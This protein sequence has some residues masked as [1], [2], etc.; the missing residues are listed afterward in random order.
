VQVAYGWYGL[1]VFLILHMAI[2]DELLLAYFC[3][4]L[5]S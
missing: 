1:F 2:S 5:D 4:L 3:G